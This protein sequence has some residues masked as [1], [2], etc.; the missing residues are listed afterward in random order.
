MIH[1][2]KKLK[3]VIDNKFFTSC[4]YLLILFTIEKIMKITAGTVLYFNK[5]LNLKLSQICQNNYL[6][7]IL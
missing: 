3:N 6:K 1:S 2:V 7:I 5:Y 4:Y